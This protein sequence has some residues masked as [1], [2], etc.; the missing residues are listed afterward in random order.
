M[1]LNE[2]TQ[3]FRW[4][5]R[6]DEPKAIRLLDVVVFLEQVV[7]ERNVALLCLGCHQSLVNMVINLFIKALG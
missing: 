4:V 7:V 6:F 1:L 5:L 2:K 3:R